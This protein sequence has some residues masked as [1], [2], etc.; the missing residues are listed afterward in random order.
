MTFLYLYYSFKQK[1]GWWSQGSHPAWNSEFPITWVFLRLFVHNTLYIFIGNQK[2]WTQPQGWSLANLCAR[3]LLHFYVWW[4][5]EYPFCWENY[6]WW[7]DHWGS[8][9]SSCVTCWR[10]VLWTITVRPSCLHLHLFCYFATGNREKKA[11]QKST[12]TKYIMISA[13]AITI[14]KPLIYQRP[15]L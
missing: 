11:K 6:M 4:N 3:W 13:R 7:T 1:Q 9:M 12:L 2:G 8:L 5:V 10:V 15:Y 14:N